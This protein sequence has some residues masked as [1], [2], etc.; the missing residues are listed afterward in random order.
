MRIAD[1]GYNG[2]DAGLCMVLVKGR[3]DKQSGYLLFLIYTMGMK[4]ND[5]VYSLHSLGSPVPFFI[6]D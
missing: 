3:P 1:G 2:C 6:S 4:N 5:L